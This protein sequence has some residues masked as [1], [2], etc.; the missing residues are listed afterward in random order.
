MSRRDIEK[1]RQ[2]MGTLPD[3]D[4][5]L[6]TKFVRGVEGISVELVDYNINPY[7][8]MYIMATTCWGKKVNKWEETDPEYRFKVVKAVLTGNALPLAL[9]APSFTFAIEGPSRA[10]FDQLARTRVGA[11]FSARG[12]RD[13]NWKDASI[14]VP[15]CLWPLHEDE[16]TILVNMKEMYA[17]IVNQGKGSWQAA[18]FCLPMNICYGWS[19]SYNYNALKGVCYNRLKFCLTENNLILLGSGLVKR[20]SE[21]EPGDKVLTQEGVYKPVKRTVCRRY[22]G[23][24]VRLTVHGQSEYES[25]ELTEDHKVFGV[26]TSQFRD[27]NGTVREPLYL[28]TLS[29]EEIRAGDLEVG[30]LI[31]YPIIKEEWDLTLLGKT[32]TKEIMKAIGYFLAEGHTTESQIVLSFGPEE[33]DLA[34]DCKRC[35]DMGFGTS[36]IIRDRTEGRY[37]ETT[38]TIKVEI[39][40]KELAKFFRREFGHLAHNKRIPDWVVYLKKEYL[41]ALYEG[42]LSGDGSLVTVTKNGKDYRFYSITSTSYQ[43]LVRLRDILLKLGKTASIGHVKYGDY[44]ETRGQRIFQ[45]DKYRLHI[46]ESEEGLLSQNGQRIYIQGDYAYYMIRKKKETIEDTLVYNL[47]ID[48][49]HSYSTVGALVR[50]CEMEDTVAT[51]WLMKKAVDEE[52]P[53]LGNYLRPGCD[54]AGKCQYHRSYTLSELFGCLF[55]ECGRNP[56][57]DSNDYAEFNEVCTNYKDLEEQLGIHIVRPDEWVD[58]DGLSDLDEKDRILFEED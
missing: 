57:P 15:T 20:I 27:K 11:V 14:R 56:C 1:L 48:D 19:V 52:F 21:I 50:N 18:R 53:L 16:E 31:A 3:Q 22:E 29:P 23:K 5:P 35:F 44:A 33:I 40:N 34:E 55:K 10:A 2:V 43:L 28:Q 4:P 26:K 58:P 7:K 6:E 41:L 25:L 36:A 8:A 32:V 45:R 54:Y 24:L 42:Y 30:D 9:E 13:N 12:V 46:T 37:K 49:I 51:A 47:E 39:G 38:N 17:D